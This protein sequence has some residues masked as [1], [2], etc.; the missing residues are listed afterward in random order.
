MK[1]ENYQIQDLTLMDET[2]NGLVFKRAIRG[3]KP[4]WKT[5]QH[6]IMHSL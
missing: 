1:I 5:H 6:A 4:G 2:T 3:L